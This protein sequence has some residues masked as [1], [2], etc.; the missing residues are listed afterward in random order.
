[1]LAL[2]ALKDIPQI[3]AILDRADNET[4]KANEAIEGANQAANEAQKI[5]LEAKQTA[6]EASKVRYQIF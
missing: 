4:R 3:E 5:A 2:E 6:N 1:M